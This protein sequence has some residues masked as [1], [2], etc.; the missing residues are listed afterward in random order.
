MEGWA[1]ANKLQ[2]GGLYAQ[3]SS[4]KIEDTGIAS[5]MSLRKIEVAV[6]LKLTATVSTAD[7]DGEWLQALIKAAPLV[8]SL[9]AHRS[10]GL[11]RTTLEVKPCKP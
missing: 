5:D 6:P 7:Y 3:L 9:G 1:E 4:T 8:R 11:G 2:L 10:R